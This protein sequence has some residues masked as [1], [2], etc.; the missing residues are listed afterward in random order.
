MSHFINS[1]YIN[2]YFNFK[3]IIIIIILFSYLCYDKNKK[4]YI[5]DNDKNIN[6]LI[7]NNFFILDSNNLGN[8]KS[9][10]YGFY[11]SKKGII[12]DNY[13]KKY[14]YYEDPKPQGAYVMVKVRGNEIEIN[15]DFQGSFGLYIYESKDK[16]YFA[17][18]NSFLLLE[19]YL[20]SKQNISLNKDFADN[21]IITHLCSPSIYE[22]MIKEIIKLPTNSYLII[23]KKN[24]SFKINYIDY[25]ENSIPLESEEGLKVIDDW[26]DKWTY[27][28]RSIK[29]KTD[30]FYFDLS[31]GFDT[32]TALSILLNSGLD[33]NN[34]QINSAKRKIHGYDEDY[35]ISKNISLKFGLKLNKLNLD[36]NYSKWSINDTLICS[37]Y[38]KLGFHK[39]FYWKDRFFTKPR[40]SFTGDGGEYIRGKPGLPIE[41]FFLK[42]LSQEKGIIGYEEEFYNA[43]M[44]LYNRSISL[45]KK[46]KKYDND[47]EISSDFY[48]RYHPNHFGKKVVEGFMANF[49]FI[50]PLI[51]PDIRKIKYNISGG[52]SHDLI[53][54]IYVRFAHDLI[55]FPFQ[56]H[57][58]LSLESIKKAE[59]LNKNYIPYIKKSDYNKNFYLDEKRI[60]PIPP[61]NNTNKTVEVFLKELFDSTNFIKIINKIYNNNV[62]DWAKKYSE[63]SKFFPL[64]HEYG[65]LAIAISIEYLSLNKR[66]MEHFDNKNSSENEVSGFMNILMKLIK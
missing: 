46:V 22:T 43:S 3:Q 45:L 11:V 49:Y 14:G 50:Q 59:K 63:K 9:H 2:N 16:K 28:I 12:T 64:R 1:I 48:E 30:N 54:Y 32:R 10:F 58:T 40:F 23:N 7:Y 61:F 41:N 65:L 39:E 35:N 24:K 42:L 62:Y 36:K 26:V 5:N 47:Y 4:K 25:K 52:F 44:R 13:Y 60:S 51:D 34:I 15:Q 20:S 29:E 27:I 53:A 66:Y 21:L 38:S 37:M 8:I 17:I 57:R 6:N 55:F 33:V 56:N 19:E 18:S 31:G